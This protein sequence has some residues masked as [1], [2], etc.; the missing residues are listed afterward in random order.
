MMEGEPCFDG[1]KPLAARSNFTGRRRR[2][3]DIVT[4]TSVGMLVVAG[5]LVA[6]RLTM[7][8]RAIAGN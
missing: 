8:I 1:R 6:V 5:G 2:V 7:V 4:L 3:A